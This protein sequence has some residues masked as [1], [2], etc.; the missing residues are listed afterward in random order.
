MS[1][2]I[3]NGYRLQQMSLMELQ[4]FAGR[5]REII[6]EVQTKLQAKN[7]ARLCATILD[8]Y[9]FDPPK[10]FDARMK[11]QHSGF[12]YG[13][14]ANIL[15][16]R[17]IWEN[18][19]RIKATQMRDPL[20][21]LDANMTVFPLADTILMII[22]C[23]Q[24]EYRDAIEAM[25]EVTPYP[26]WNNEDRPDDLSDNEWEQREGVW[27]S[28]LP[29]I[30]IPSMCGLILQC[31]SGIMS[32]SG[33]QILEAMPSIEQRAKRRAYDNLMLQ[34]AD[35]S[36]RLSGNITFESALGIMDHLQTTPD[37]Q[38]MLSAETERI[39]ALL[40]PITKADICVELIRK[41]V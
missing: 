15:A 31:T 10:D 22:F 4:S 12:R 33:K 20:Y 2:K 8:D 25:P 21:D 32:P 3:Y 39:M 1:T 29:G 28:A 40:K 24:K 18:E 38:A 34:E 23:E 41:S 26:Y 17:I 6:Q 9:V 14:S 35:P 30:G 7:Y 13:L 19:K 5:V 27:E 11:S 16:K 36:S 37:G